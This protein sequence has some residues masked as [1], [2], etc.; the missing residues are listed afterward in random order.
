M[1]VLVYIL[2]LLLA[3]AV[4]AGGSALLVALSPGHVGWLLLLATMSLTV[5]V[6]GPLML[7]SLG[8]FW[9]V[10]KSES[11]RRYLAWWYRITLALEALAAVAIVV[12]A[13]LTDAPVWLPVLFIAG[14]AVLTVIAVFVGSWLRKREAASPPETRP[15]APISRRDIIRKTTKVVVTFV[16]AV[17]VGTGLLAALGRGVFEDELSV[18]AGLVV[19][20]AFIAA[21][22]ACILVT[23]PLLKRMRDVVD[24]DAGLLRKL[25]K[26]V[27]K[28]KQIDLDEEEQVQA[29]RYAAVASV[30]LPF[31]LTYLAL[32]YVGIGIQQLQLVTH[33]SVRPKIIG[34]L[35]LLLVVL[36][37]TVPLY[38]R[39]ARRARDYARDHDELLP[40]ARSSA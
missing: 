25:A 22:M 31:Q 16:V 28:A 34:T 29:A 18:A 37:V 1:K 5:F 23:M 11:S 33:P 40:V 13:V 20:V 17:V 36:V 7:G 35:A 19:G 3:T 9:D 24:R 6:Y 14:G 12:Y 30:A 26:G 38:V 21:S 32:L 8:A 39:Y 2:S 27:L 15:W 10:R 4:V